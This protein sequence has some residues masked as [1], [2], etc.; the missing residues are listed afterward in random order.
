MT[1]LRPQDAACRLPAAGPTIAPGHAKGND[2]G[3]G[4]AVFTE[5]RPPGGDGTGGGWMGADRPAAGR[6]RAAGMA[7]KNAFWSFRLTGQLGLYIRLKP[8]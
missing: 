2:P 1:V 3:P 6:E 4:L 7:G 8:T 5:E